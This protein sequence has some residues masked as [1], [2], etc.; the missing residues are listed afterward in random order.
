MM[1]QIVWVPAVAI[2]AVVLFAAAMIFDAM[3]K[4][5]GS[6]LKHTPEVVQSIMSTL[7]LA[8]LPI[9]LIMGVFSLSLLSQHGPGG[10][11]TLQVWL[12]S[13]VALPAAALFVFCIFVVNDTC[14]QARWGP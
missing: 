2:V 1:R 13:G 7:G 12:F 14:N 9:S 8:M 3:A 5:D 10:G 6:S 4:E 11:E